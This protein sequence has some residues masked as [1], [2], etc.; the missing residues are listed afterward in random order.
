MLGALIPH[1]IPGLPTMAKAYAAEHE[2]A[3]AHEPG[4]TDHDCL[5]AS[6]QEQGALP[7][8]SA[9]P[10][11]RLSALPVNLLL[12]P[13]ASLRGLAPV[14]QLPAF[15]RRTARASPPYAEAFAR[16]SRLLI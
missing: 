3:L 6:A 11:P 8:V 9:P 2:H 16:T 15:E 1:C 5:A 12:T 4:D 14:P 13:L 10:S 7:S